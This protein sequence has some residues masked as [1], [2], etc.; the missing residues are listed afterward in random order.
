M[1]GYACDET[2]ELMPLPI[3]LAH[4]LTKPA[5]RRAQEAALSI[6]APRRQEP[7][8]RA[9][10][11]DGQPVRIDAVVVSTQHT[12][13]VKNKKI[14]EAVMEEVIKPVLPAKLVDNKT[15]YFINPTGRFVVG[16]PMGDSG[17]TGRKIIVDTYGGMGRHG[18]GAF[19]GKD[20][21]KVDRSACYYAPLHRQERGGRRP[22]PPLRGAGRL[23]HRRGRAGVVLVETFGTGDRRPRTQIAA[24][25]R[26]NFDARPRAIIRELDLLR[27]I[28]QKTAAYGH[29]GR[30][31]EGVHLGAHRQGRPPPRRRPQRRRHQP[32]QRQERPRQERPGQAHRQAQIPP[33]L[34]HRRRLSRSTPPPTLPGATERRGSGSSGAPSPGPQTRRPLPKGRG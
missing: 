9:V 1:F 31:R 7:G 26:A 15:K 17:V 11:R 10:R 19:S 22:G 2:P 30:S 33:H 13:S 34:H 29:F 27:P 6:P 14:H 24:I 18:G 21:S 32:P 16:G 12:E 8:D 3:M 4:K 28:Y 5:G 23:R 20:P 25:V